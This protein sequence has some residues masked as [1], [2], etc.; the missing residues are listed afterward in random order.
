M[1]GGTLPTF[2]IT[3]ASITPMLLPLLVAV[4]REMWMVAQASR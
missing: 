2:L 3:E 1:D 4:G